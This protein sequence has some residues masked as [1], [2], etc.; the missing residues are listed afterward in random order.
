VSKTCF[1]VFFQRTSFL[2]VYGDLATSLRFADYIDLI[3][4]SPDEL[5]KL[6]DCRVNKRSQCFG[7]GGG[8][9]VV[10]RRGSIV[11]YRGQWMAAYRAAVPLAHA[12]QLPL[13]RL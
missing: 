3:A 9:S 4:E 2:V 12:N 11:R 13:P 10:L 6:T 1:S 8:M 5:Q 7:Y